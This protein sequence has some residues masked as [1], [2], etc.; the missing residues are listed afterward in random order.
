M[1]PSERSNEIAA[2]F[3]RLLKDGDKS[4]IKKIEYKE[5]ETAIFHYYLDKNMGFYKAM[6]SR[7][8]E[9]QDNKKTKKGCWFNLLISIIA[10]ILSWIL[11]KSCS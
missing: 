9:L 10:V 7:L 8:K 4:T 5:L 2:A 1:P 11:L 6:E 3:Q